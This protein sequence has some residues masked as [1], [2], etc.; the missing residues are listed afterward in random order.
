MCAMKRRNDHIGLVQYRR[1]KR[2]RRRKRSSE[3]ELAG[4]LAAIHTILKEY[5]RRI[6]IRHLFYRLESNKV[7]EKT[8]LDYKRL[9]YHLGQ[10]R[11]SHEIKWSAFS[12]STRWY[13]RAPTFDGIDDALAQTVETY[14]R[15]L[16]RDQPY[17]VEVWVEK[18]AMLS[19]I[20]DVTLK[21]G[22]PAFTCKGFNSLTSLFDASETFHRAMV[23]GK[24]VIVLHLGDYDPSGKTAVDAMERT[25]RKDFDCKITMKRLA[26]TKEQIR[27]FKL[28]T[29]PPKESTHSRDWEGKG[30][31]ELDAFPVEPLCRLL[32][33]AITDLID[34]FAWKQLRNIETGE[35]DTMALAAVK[36]LKIT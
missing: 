9:C 14:R 27:R 16:W 11:R 2:K 22:V 8:E 5:K 30:C 36:I 20:S 1:Q 32:E 4:L 19:I 24:K 25:L 3:D 26:V 10:W 13:V 7:I 35:R 23:A 31:V 15:D 12:D 21:W 28:P 34:R 6:S 29:R 17:Y 33:K 18:E